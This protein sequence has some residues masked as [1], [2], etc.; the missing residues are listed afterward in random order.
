MGA[1]IWNTKVAKIRKSKE[2]TL[3]FLKKID[4]SINER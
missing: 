3:L 1:N 2:L 4:A